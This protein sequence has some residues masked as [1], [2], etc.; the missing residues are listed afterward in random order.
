[1]QTQFAW[2]CA[3]LLTASCHIAGAKADP[4]AAAPEP[5][6][7]GLA[8]DKALADFYRR[9]QVQSIHL[10]VADK[11]LQRML[12]ALPER[13]DVLASFRWRDVAVE[14]VSIRFKGNSSSHP[15]QSHKRSFLIKFDKYDKKQRFFGLRQ[16]AFDN[17]IQF[18]SLFSEPIITDILR[19]HGIQ[20]HRCNYA[21]LYFNKEY[22]GVYVNVERIDQSFI[23]AH[24]PDKAGPLFKVDLGG[25]GANLQYLGDEPAHYAKAFETKSKSAKKEIVRLVTFIRWINQSEP[26][27]FAK[28]FDSKLEADDFLRTT[29]IL[30]LAGAFDQLTGWNP[31]NYFLYHDGKSDRW[32]YLPWDLDVGFCETAFGKIR[33]LADWNA[34]WPVPTS[35]A[36]NPL[37]ERIIAD[38]QLLARYRKEARKI[39][40]KSFEPDRRRCRETGKTS[41]RSAR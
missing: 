17:G 16:V 13:I 19:D 7:R 38:P 30:L 40:D 36:P 37:L 26:K 4:P 39:L 11:D 29:A 2:T 32:R 41:R 34:S 24:L 14:N 31:H 10:Q 20:T 5:S 18:G 6:A 25:P 35:G 22:Q 23:D 3:V 1:M 33:V 28:N 21:K 15:K 8:A 12:A 9:E 27:A